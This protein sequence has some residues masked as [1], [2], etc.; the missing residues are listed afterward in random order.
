MKITL[1]EEF[2]R[3]QKLAG[4]L[5]EYGNQGP[6]TP[7]VYILDTKI[8]EVIPSSMKEV[9]KISNL[10]YDIGGGET[11]YFDEYNIVI[12]GQKV[13][14]SIYYRHIPGLTW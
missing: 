6:T 4:I 11:S 1:S 14:Y 10:I 7:E 2:K 9:Q 5:N 12:V 13:D 8:N 3:M